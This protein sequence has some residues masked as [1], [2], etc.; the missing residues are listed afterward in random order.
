MGSCL[1]WYID[2][3]R[4]H[5]L[6]GKEIHLSLFQAHLV[7]CL[8]VLVHILHLSQY[9]LSHLGI[10]ILWYDAYANYADYVKMQQ[11]SPYILPDTRLIFMVIYSDTS[12]RTERRTTRGVDTHPFGGSSKGQQL[13]SSYCYV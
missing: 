12:E 1:D 2:M 5:T 3:K 13:L 7:V 9:R 10:A 6:F 11:L 8:M 4:S